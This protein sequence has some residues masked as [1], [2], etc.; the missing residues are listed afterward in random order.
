M[1]TTGTFLAPARIVT[2]LG[3]LTDMHIRE[4]GR[5]AYR[6]IDTAP[7]LARAVA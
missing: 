6:P 3:Q 2:L 5:L 1:N 4:P 7:F